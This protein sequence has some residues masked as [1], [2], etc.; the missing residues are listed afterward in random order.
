MERT[1]ANPGRLNKQKHIIFFF[2]KK[3]CCSSFDNLEI[4]PQT[5][6]FKQLCNHSILCHCRKR[7]SNIDSLVWVSL[8]LLWGFKSFPECLWI[9]ATST[10]L[11]IGIES[12]DLAGSAGNFL[13]FMWLV[14]CNVGCTL[15]HAQQPASLCCSAL[16]AIPVAG[17]LPLQEPELVGMRGLFWP[18]LTF[19]VSFWL[20]LSCFPL[21]HLA[22]SPSPTGLS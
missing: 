12:R 22:L 2:K 16:Q 10:L 7:A 20:S 3:P 17:M 5:A 11:T 13:K 14:D 19:C 9:W 21:S 8:Y 15:Y 6:I 18:R 1:S 4:N